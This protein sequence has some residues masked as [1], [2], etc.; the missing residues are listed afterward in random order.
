MTRTHSRGH[1]TAASAVALTL[2][3]AAACS[4]SSHASVPAASNH[5][6]VA[7]AHPSKSSLLHPK[8]K[9]YG[10]F[11]GSS[12]ASLAPIDKIAG[13]T[14]KK[15][16]LVMWF[17]DWGSGAASGKVNFAP[18]AAEDACAAGI[19]PLYTWESWNTAAHSSN[20]S[21]PYAQPAFA[22]KRIVSGAY[23][24]YIRN[25]AKAM[26]ATHC[27]IVVRLD[28]EQNGYWYP[29]GLETTGMGSLRDTAQEYVMMWR[30]VWRIFHNQGATNVL[31]MWSPNFQSRPGKGQPKLSKSYP[32]NKYVDWVG[33][34]GYYV[35]NPKQTFSKLFGPTVKQLTPVAASKPFIVAETAVGT[36]ST[37][38]RQITNLLTSI[39]KSKRFNGFVYFDYYA[40][41]K[42][43]YWP[44]Q[45]T[46][47]SLA[48]FKAGIDK[49]A[50]GAAKPGTL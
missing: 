10:I 19:L 27:P 37:K 22:A 6:A 11:D 47:A 38:P 44:F 33:I 28:Q 39:A 1:I 40:N 31:W 48:A 3:V 36:G 35:D 14:G 32:G 24:S 9:Y 15:P 17:Q 13:E 46:A 41:G 7:T 16:N 45:Q 18:K 23:D 42:R 29:W 25:T 50:F 2:V 20:P 26:R 4:A 5:G 34:D 21:S 30:H 49:S 8:R 43:S 12:P